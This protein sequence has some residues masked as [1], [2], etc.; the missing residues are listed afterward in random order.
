MVTFPF[1]SSLIGRRKHYIYIIVCYLFI[2][3]QTDRYFYNFLFLL[4]Y[5]IANKFLLDN[6]GYT[7]KT[8][9]YVSILQSFFYILFSFRLLKIDYFFANVVGFVIF[10][11]IYINY[12]GFKENK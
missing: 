12:F 10:N 1:I 3:L 6:T 11:Y 2:S 4:I 8:I 9:I 7:K 5:V